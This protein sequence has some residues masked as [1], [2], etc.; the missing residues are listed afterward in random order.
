MFNTSKR[1]R[2]RVDDEEAMLTAGDGV[3]LGFGKGDYGLEYLCRRLGVPVA[4]GAGLS[5]IGAILV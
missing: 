2:E 3:G 5:L 1:E 4:Q